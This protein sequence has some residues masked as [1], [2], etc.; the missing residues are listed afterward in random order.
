[1]KPESSPRIFNYLD[2]NGNKYIITNEFIEYLPIKPPISSSGVYNGGYNTKKEINEL[3]Y[4][5]LVKNLFKALKNKKIHI[6]NRIKMSGVIIIKER[7]KQKT[8]IL[9]PG[10]EEILDI[11]TL[12]KKIIS[13]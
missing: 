13:D 7:K 4:D 3:D 12:L 2:G 10:S 6:K 5:I 1:M 8:Y 11:E 9:K